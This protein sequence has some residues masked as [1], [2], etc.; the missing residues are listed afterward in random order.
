MSLLISSSALA[1]ENCTD[2]TL[3]STASA[4]ALVEENCEVIDQMRSCAE[5]P[6]DPDAA[7]SG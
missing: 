2:P 6:I 4:E 5:K 1:L 3:S 7:T